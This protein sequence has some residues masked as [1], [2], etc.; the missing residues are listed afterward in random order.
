MVELE[1]ENHE[2][3]CMKAVESV[4]NDRNSFLTGFNVHISSCL[5][6]DR[7]AKDFAPY[8]PERLPI[9]KKNGLDSN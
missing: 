3:A 4:R 7:G 6:N 8:V 1:A 5:I 9:E 2:I